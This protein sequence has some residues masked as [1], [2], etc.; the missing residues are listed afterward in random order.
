MKR[1][2]AEWEKIFA[3]DA[4]DKGLIYKIH[5][6][7]IQLNI[8]KKK[9]QHNPGEKWAE[10]LTRYFC[11]EDMQMANRHVKKCLTSLI[12]YQINANQ[13]YNE[14]GITLLW[15]EWPSPKSLQIINVGE[16]VE[17][18]ESSCQVGGIVNWYSYYGEQ[19]GSSLKDYKQSFCMI[20]QCHFWACIWRKL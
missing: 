16:G 19:S 11:K 18:K 10:D 2:L 1:Q 7:L 4:T 14:V 13:S 12:N 20:L 3:N 5:K 9:T 17:K 8:K 6:Q 15:S